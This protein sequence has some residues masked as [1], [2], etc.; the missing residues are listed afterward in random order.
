MVRVNNDIGVKL[1]KGYTDGEYNYYY[2]R[3]YKRWHCIEPYTGL[4]VAIG[5]TRAAAQKNGKHLSCKVVSYKDSYA[6]QRD[7]ERF[8]SLRLYG[9]QIT[10]KD[11]ERKTK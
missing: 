5:D 2:E 10:A 4:S 6:Y 1:Q 9:G 3:E 11:L 8:D 7:R